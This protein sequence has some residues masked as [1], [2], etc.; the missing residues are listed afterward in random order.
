MESELPSTECERD[1][2]RAEN[3]KLREALQRLVVRLDEDFSG[4]R[5]LRKG[6]VDKARAALAQKEESNG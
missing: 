6:E 5:T 3:A 2:L 1:A 4:V